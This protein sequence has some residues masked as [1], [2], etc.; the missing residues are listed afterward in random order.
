MQR[1]TKDV[2]VYELKSTCFNAWPKDSSKVKTLR[3]KKSEIWCLWSCSKLIVVVLF[4]T[5]C[6][7]PLGFLLTPQPTRHVQTS[8]THPSPSRLFYK[9]KTPASKPVWSNQTAHLDMHHCHKKVI[10]QTVWKAKESFKGTFYG[11]ILF[12]LPQLNVTFLHCQFID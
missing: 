4:V 8:E 2:L 7:G 12:L 3:C 6:A 11:E 5:H 10:F 1:E 9:P